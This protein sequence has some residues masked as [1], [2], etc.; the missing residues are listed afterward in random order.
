VVLD[1]L[2]YFDGDG[3]VVVYSSTMTG[4]SRWGVQLGVNVGE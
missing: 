1:V 4:G 2:V 3:D